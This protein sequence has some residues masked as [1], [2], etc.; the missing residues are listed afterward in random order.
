M[1][2]SEALKRIKELEAELEVSDRL[3]KDRTLLLEA[4]PQC[5]VHGECVPYALEWIEQVKT[6]ARIVSGNG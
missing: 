4:I 1:K 6:L 5:P 3:L 2:L